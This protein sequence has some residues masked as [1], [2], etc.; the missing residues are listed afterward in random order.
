M[1]D[2]N[3]ILF[4]NTAL[5][6]Q[7]PYSNDSDP[8][9]SCTLS[10]AQ[11]AGWIW[12]IGLPTRRGIGHVYSS[13]HNSE[14][15]AAEELLSY[16]ATTAG[17]QAAAAATLRKVPFSPGHRAKFWHK[18]CVAVGMSA[19]FIEPLE[20]SAL[21]LVELSAAMIAEQLPANRDHM[22]LVA[23]RFNDKFLYRWDSIIEFLKLHY[24]LTQ[25]N[26]TDYWRDNCRP[27]SIPESLQE[28][29]AL[30]RHQSPWHRDSHHVDELFPSAS[31]QYILYGMGFETKASHTVRRSDAEAQKVVGRLFQ[32]NAARAQQL[33]GNMPSNRDLID[34]IHS[35]GFQKI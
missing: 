24:I 32:E 16:I 33:S 13:A 11:T 22:D 34:K 10:T 31:F 29:V 21:V 19:G 9:A 17:E 25:R 15:R 30:W 5:A 27:A 18:N 28:K 7:I 20:A 35:Y 4:N 2:K 3:D 12:D 26:D 1:C 14:E 8:I 6:A 23:K